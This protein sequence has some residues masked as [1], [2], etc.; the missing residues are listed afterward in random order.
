MSWRDWDNSFMAFK[1]FFDGGVTHSM[2]SSHG[3][4]SFETI[5]CMDVLHVPIAYQK[6]DNGFVVPAAQECM[7]HIILLR[8]AA[9]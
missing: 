3:S 4:V 5:G 6:G 7:P 2:K 8:H 9:C 1:A